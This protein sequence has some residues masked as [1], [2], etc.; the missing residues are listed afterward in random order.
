MVEYILLLLL[1]IT[2]LLHISAHAA[3]P[4]GETMKPHYNKQVTRFLPK[5]GA[6]CAEA[7]RRDL[8]N[9]IYIYLFNCMYAF[10]WYIKDITAIQ[11]ATV[12]SRT[13]HE[14]PEGG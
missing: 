8:I 9:N 1:F 2:S 3:N 13:G 6:V 7:C 14:G 12:H 10:S 4:Q 5:N 11:Q